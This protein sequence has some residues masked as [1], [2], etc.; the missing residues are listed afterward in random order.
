MKQF[1]RNIPI[2]GRGVVCVAKF[3]RRRG[4]HPFE[5]SASYW[6]DRYIAGGNSGRGS[7]G[8]LAQFKADIINKFVE[9]HRVNSVIEFGCGDGNQLLLA[10]YPS[11]HGFDVSSAALELCRLQFDVDQ[12]KRF[13]LMQDYAGE[14]AELSLSL[15]VIYHL[16]EDDVYECYLSRLF[17]AARRYVVIY[18]SNFESPSP[19]E[20]PHVRHRRF[21]DWVLEGEPHWQLIDHIQNPYPC[22]D[23]NNRGSFA[24]FYFFSR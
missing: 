7:Y 8:E 13:S 18:S 20:V 15:D 4:S 17:N 14:Q 6:E 21:T 10:R 24:D 1:V 22:N 9:R 23:E 19:R 16:V 2:L 5:N 3:L 12:T 11:Y